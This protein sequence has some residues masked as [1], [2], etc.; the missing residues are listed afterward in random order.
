MPSRR[1]GWLNSRSPMRLRRRM[2]LAR[3]FSTT[4]F[5]SRRFEKGGELDAQ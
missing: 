3:L 5:S 1:S 2:W 4:G